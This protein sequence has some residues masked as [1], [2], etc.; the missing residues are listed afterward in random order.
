MEREALRALVR[1]EL[2]KLILEDF[3]IKLSKITLAPEEFLIVKVEGDM[4]AK[5]YNNVNLILK[6]HFGK[7]ALVMGSTKAYNIEI[8]KGVAKDG[9]DR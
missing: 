1:E 5:F 8:V 7:R 4:D 3:P 6:E 2:D 9:E